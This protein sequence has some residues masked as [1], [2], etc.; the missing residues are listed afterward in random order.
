MPI[1]ATTILSVKANYSQF[2]TFLSFQKQVV[3][4]SAEP[5]ISTVQNQR[6]S[7]THSQDVFGKL[8]WVLGVASQRVRLTS[9]KELNGRRN[10]AG[11]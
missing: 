8:P 7:R 3:L 6:V 9:S 4:E 10:G 2:F 11:A 1:F 5:A